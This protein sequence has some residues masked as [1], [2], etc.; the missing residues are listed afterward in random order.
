MS[1][2][3]AMAREHWQRHLPEAYASLSDPDDY[4][5]TLG[6]EALEQVVNLA[7]HLRGEDPPDEL[8]IDRATRYARARQT[9]EEVVIHELLLTRPQDS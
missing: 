9:A 3:A 1:G 7:E 4:F 2:F 8:F 6:A 5:E